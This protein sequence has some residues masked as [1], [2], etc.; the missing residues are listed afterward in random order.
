[1]IVT[2]AFNSGDAFEVLDTGV[3]IGMTPFVPVGID[4]GDDPVPCLANPGMSHAE[5]ALAAGG[6]SF[7]I[8]PLA[9]PSGGG[10]A[11][12]IVN[13]SV[14]EPS[15]WLLTMVAGLGVVISA[16]QRRL[17]FPRRQHGCGCAPR[18]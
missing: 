11:Y 16:A 17:L 8:A 10:A 14:P 9:S 2:D 18:P 5:F 15:I 12:F 4:C 7:T 3:P 13:R 1:L 6:H